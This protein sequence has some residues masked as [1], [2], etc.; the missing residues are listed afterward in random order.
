M[1]I[2]FLDIGLDPTATIA[3]ARERSPLYCPLMDVRFS[4]FI[5]YSHAADAQVA[6]ALQRTLQRVGRP[7]WGRSQLRIFRDQT[8]LAAA[9][10]LWSEIEKC[11]ATSSWFIYLASPQAATSSWVRQELQWWLSRRSAEHV[12]IVLTG[13]ELVWDRDLHRFD[14]ARSS[15]LPD[16][17]MAAFAEEPLWVDLRWAQSQSVPRRTLSMRHPEFREATLTLAARLLSRE[18]DELE[19][20]D[21]REQRRRVWAVGIGVLALGA[22]TVIAAFGLWFA[23]E[24]GQRAEQNWREAQSRRLAALADVAL[25]KSDVRSAIQLGVLAWR[26]DRTAEARQTMQRLV[27]S[28]GAVS[29][30][31]EAHSSG[32]A[33]LS[34]APD[35]QRFV[36]LGHDGSVQQWNVNGW[37]R[38]GPMLAP[39]PKVDEPSELRSRSDRY[40]HLGAGLTFD[41]TGRHVLVW[42][43]VG[44]GWLWDLSSGTAVR[45]DTALYTERYPRRIDTLAIAPG[46]KR[47]LLAGYELLAAWRPGTAGVEEVTRL[48]SGTSAYATCV[49]RAGVMRSLIGRGGD[50]LRIAEVAPSASAPRMGPL[51]PRNVHARHGRVFAQSCSRLLLW[52]GR[53]PSPDAHVLEI[54]TGLQARD[55]LVVSTKALRRDVE[56]DVVSGQLESSGERLLIT[57]VKTGRNPPTAWRWQRWDVAKPQAPIQEGNL[58]NVPGG[59]VSPDGRWLVAYD[60]QSVNV[61]SFGAGSANGT[62]PSTTLHAAC[63]EYDDSCAESLCRKVARPFSEAELRELFGIADYEVFYDSHKRVVDAAACSTVK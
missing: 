33:A 41:V 11:L 19:G 10:G 7:W 39:P 46:G 31:L 5:S 38:L 23:A 55:V 52:S 3:R 13:G 17:L 21:L 32:I 57:V 14:A 61:W 53:G 59:I 43:A 56:R 47:V 26:L 27:E 29:Q 9:P 4:A 18:K 30:V 60:T 44:T 22:T 36:T 35:S 12:L 24:R 63:R 49:D 8:H 54:D 34:F 20:A 62:S 58:E 45:F 50:G 15:S 1:P 40:R 42:H 51:L 6:T 16:E 2:P 28:G 48:R 37:Q 25:T